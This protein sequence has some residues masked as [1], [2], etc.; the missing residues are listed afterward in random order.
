MAIDPLGALSPAATVG[1]RQQTSTPAAPAAAAMLEAAVVDIDAV[2]AAKVVTPAA[3]LAGAPRAGD[4]LTLRLLDLVAPPGGGPLPPGSFAAT[5]LQG[6]GAA[7]LLATPLGLLAL[8]TPLDLP[9]GTILV[10]RRTAPSNPSPAAEPAARSSTEWAS[11][12]L[13]RLTAGIAGGALLRALDP[14][15]GVHLAAGLMLLAGRLQASIAGERTRLAGRAG[16]SDGAAADGEAAESPAVAV[17]DPAGDAWSLLGLHLFDGEH[18][19]PL[20]LAVKRPPD[21]ERA[22]GGAR[23]LLEVELSR[24]GGLQFDGRVE[25]RRLDLLLRTRAALAPELRTDLA[26]MFH[27]A[28][29]AA[30]LA[31]EIAFTTTWLLLAPRAATS[32]DAG[33]SA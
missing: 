31:G 28:K 6:S 17:S 10:L 22:E 14:R 27:D 4:A 7:R 30:G 18:P 9:A 32:G 12:R 26:A 21:E 8:E 3:E 1:P 20:R 33:F 15:D 13:D 24:L 2:L 11:D 16:R 23:F 19:M 29:S 5:L 25:G